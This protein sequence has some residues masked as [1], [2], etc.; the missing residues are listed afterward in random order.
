M[1]MKKQNYLFLL[2]ASLTIILSSCAS[3]RPVKYANREWRISDY[4]GQIIDRDTTYRMTFGDVLIPSQLN[5][6]ASADSAAK[7][8]GMERFIAEILHTAGLENNEVLF[9]TPFMGT[10]FVRLTT[11]HLAT[12]PSSISCN[13]DDDKPHTFWV[14]D[15]DIEEWQRPHNEMY[16]YTYF[17]RR[18]QRVLI[19]DYYDYGEIPIARISVLQ[20]RNKMTDRMNLPLLW[21]FFKHD[22]K[23]YEKDIEFWSNCIDSHR[24][25]SFA[26]YKI[27]KESGTK[28][29]FAAYGEECR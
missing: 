28:L 1:R 15:D 25:L 16:T 22:L 4:Y 6:I 8:P 10:M 23:N 7:Y 12:R 9:Y 18:K 2:S 20:S 24:K 5:I 13:L 29:S 27:G 3:L 19:V 21:T 26:N 14:Y 11:E 17:D